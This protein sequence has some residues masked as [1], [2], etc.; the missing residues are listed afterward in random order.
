M[1]EMTMQ[2]LRDFVRI[3]ADTDITDAPDSSL[4]LYARMAVDDATQRIPSV[5]TI[6]YLRDTGVLTTTADQRFY[7]NADG[8][9]WA[10]YTDYAYADNA[11]PYQVLGVSY[12][13]DNGNTAYQLMYV[14]LEDGERLFPESTVRTEK[15]TAYAVHE[16]NVI[17]YPTPSVGSVL[18]DVMYRS[19]DLGAW[20]V[21][22]ADVCPLPAGLHMAVAWFMLAQYYLAQ[23]DVQL[24]GVYMQE[25]EMMVERHKRF[26]AGRNV[27]KRV[28]VIGGQNVRP[29]S[30]T[31]WVRG[32]LEG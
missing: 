2:E 10:Y 3:H 8:L 27:G 13:G 20:P 28:N 18:Y 7:Y 12:S 29:M 22:A 11:H 4:D 24:S 6:N 19:H 31:R 21:G 23:E 1:A 32:Q 9:G 25:Y 16:G 17:L 15:A 5:S 26:L 14:T 30:F